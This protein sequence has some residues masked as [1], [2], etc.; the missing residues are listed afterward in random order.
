MTTTD[1]L[2]QR[3]VNQQIVATTLKKPEALVA[4]MGAMQA[5]E[6]AMAKWAI[7]LRLPG[8]NDISVEKAFNEGAILRTHILRP[9]W[10]FVTPADIRW[11]VTLTAPR[12]RASLRYMDRKLGLD[13]ATI[14]RG[15]AALEKILAG[16]KQL[17]RDE[18]STALGHAK[19]KAIG[20]YLGNLLM[21]AELAM[22]VCSGPRRGKNFTYTLLDERVPITP[23]LGHDESLAKLANRY[24]SSRGPATLQDFCWW[25]SLTIKEAQRAVSSLDNQLG[26]ETISG[27]EFYFASNSPQTATKLTTSFLMPDYDE[28]GIAY[29]NRAILFDQSIRN[30]PVLAYNRMVIVNGLILGTWKRESAATTVQIEIA[31]FTPI[32][33]TQRQAIEQ[34]TERYATFL[35]VK[36]ELRFREA[37]NKEQ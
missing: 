35:G 30:E 28:Y 1:I 13:A 23:A 26:R 25:A 36:P 14:N 27:Q 29:K 3:L 17:V 34:A 16:G 18:I 21:H 31:P 19:I 32:T 37:N 2:S 4:W 22:L 24:F 10:H 11:I 12:V 15:L 20:Q 33:R 8:S 9:T 7:G 5:Q 6:Y